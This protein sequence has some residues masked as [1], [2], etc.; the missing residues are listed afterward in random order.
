MKFAVISSKQL[1]ET[2][3]W[4]A[5]YN[6]AYA[7]N[8]EAVDKVLSRYVGFDAKE[9]LLELASAAPRSAVACHY[10]CKRP[11][12]EL[13]SLNK[14]ELALYLIIAAQNVDEEVVAKAEDLKKQAV[15]LNEHAQKLRELLNDS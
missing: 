6:I 14:S 12:Q 8:K 1:S 9:R 10:V 13:T 3:R 4:D 5:R 11:N 7:E 2:G 15:Q